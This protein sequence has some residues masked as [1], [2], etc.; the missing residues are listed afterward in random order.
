[1]S[2]GFGGAVSETQGLRLVLGLGVTKSLA[3]LAWS[4]GSPVSP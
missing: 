1:M 4:S 3:Q 2:I